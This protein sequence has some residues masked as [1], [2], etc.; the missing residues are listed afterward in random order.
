VEA[1]YNGNT[2]AITFFGFREVLFLKHTYMSFG[3]SGHQT[4]GEVKALY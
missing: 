4:A 3:F 2:W 1:S